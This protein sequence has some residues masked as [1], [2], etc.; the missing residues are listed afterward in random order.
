M[1][2]KADFSA[3]NTVGSL[4]SG[5][6]IAKSF[7]VQVFTSVALSKLHIQVCHIWRDL[8]SGIVPR[9]ILIHSDSTAGRRPVSVVRSPAGLRVAISRPIGIM[10]WIFSALFHRRRGKLRRF[11]SDISKI[12]WHGR[13]SDFSVLFFFFVFFLRVKIRRIR[14]QLN[15]AI[16]L[17][18]LKK[19]T[20][21]RYHCENTP[22][23]EKFQT[24]RI[25]GPFLTRLV[26]RYLPLA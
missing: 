19:I 15:T 4:C 9:R 1:K 12:F 6:A 16:T 14:V 24:T 23:W 17:Y 8:N 21:I 3:T 22:A 26:G 11:A 5:V 7:I 18:G 25:V 13:I 2:L 20:L 10:R